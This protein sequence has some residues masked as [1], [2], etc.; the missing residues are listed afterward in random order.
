MTPLIS[1]VT[2]SFNRLDM[3][4]NLCYSV[5]RQ[6]P[7]GI[8][9]EIIVVD[10][11][12]EDGT[13]AWCEGEPDITLIRH[14]GLHGAIK[15]F[16][17]GAKAA[18][19]KYVCLANDDVKIEGYSL[20]R[21]AAY[22]EEHPDCGAVA[23][24]ENRVAPGYTADLHVQTIS[25]Y[26][27]GVPT[28]VPYMQ[29][30]LI[31]RWLGDLANWWSMGDPLEHTYGGDS[32][33]SAWLW[34]HGYTVDEVEHCWID[35]QVAPDGLREHNYRVEQERGS[36]F[37]R[38]YANGVHIAS[39]PKPENL[40]IPALRV[41]AATLYE[42]GFGKY[43]RG[44]LEAFG[45]VGLAAEVDFV[46]SG[47]ADKLI[48]VAEAW[49]PH[50]IWAQMVDPVLMSY[51]RQSC[52]SAVIVVWHGD[53]Y[54][55]GNIMKGMLQQAA[56][57]DLML[58]VNASAIADFEAHDILAAFWQIGWE[59]VDPLPTER[60]H[61]I[62]F[63]ANAYSESRRQL[64]AFLRGLPYNVGIYGQGWRPASDGLTLYNFARGAALY[65]RCKIAIGDSQYTKDA[66]F[67][68]NRFVEA[69]AH[70]AFLLHQYVPELEQWTGFV[71]GIHYVSWTD[72]DDLARLIE[73][74]MT[75]EDERKQIAA[76]GRKFVRENYSFDCQVEKLLE[77][78]RGI[79]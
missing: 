64:G 31:R 14:D 37:Y 22:L 70:G 32:H 39:K 45:R 58:V 56:Y 47:G 59:P 49:Q 72:T 51:L 53:V 54:R 7:D 57:I 3:L 44:L 6:I 27:N 76:A 41:L 69:L 48:R 77:L 19:G 8:G 73:Y 40:D 63:M 24:A 23:F 26:R 4:K 35:D 11:N 75:H 79:A 12:S 34:E 17:D 21:A 38:T 62:L 2:G 29:V 36:A 18:T 25:A 30:G 46:A 33:L 9:Y 65:E 68:S 66:A 52:P 5:R 60:S 13:Q 42:P 28:S 10:G 78:I 20:I 15:A 43:K 71:D 16:C 61:D 67:V 55:D 74:Y 50:L 1:V